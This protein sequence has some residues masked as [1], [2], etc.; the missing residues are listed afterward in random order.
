MPRGAKNPAKRAM[1]QLDFGLI[2]PVACA[3]GI[4]QEIGRYVVPPGTGIAAGYGFRTGQHDAEGR[5]RAVIN[6]ATPALIPGLLRVWS[7]LPNGR[8]DRILAEARSES[9]AAN[10]A[11]DRATWDPFPV[12]RHMVR[13]LGAIVLMFTADVAATVSAADTVIFMDM[14][15]FE[16]A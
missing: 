3:A 14:T 10:S 5:W 13:Y 15:E 16:A 2:A 8:P 1:T 11:T 4:A 9:L 7:Y 6:D 12:V